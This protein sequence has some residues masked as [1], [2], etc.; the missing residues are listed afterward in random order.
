MT[1]STSVAPDI[2]EGI[3]TPLSASQQVSAG[4]VAQG[5]KFDITVGGIGF[6]LAASDQR[7]YIRQTAPVQKQQIDTSKEAGEHT[8]DGEWIRSQTSWHRGAGIRSEEHTSE[9]QSRRDL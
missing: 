1:F 3:P 8:L 4:A 5:V 6:L 7:P 2:T 9:L